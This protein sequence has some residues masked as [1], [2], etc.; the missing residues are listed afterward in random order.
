[1][2]DVLAAAA[3]SDRVLAF[4]PPATAH[5]TPALEQAGRAATARCVRPA[6]GS[7]PRTVITWRRNE[8]E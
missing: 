5:E 1:M 4:P 2:D 6:R 7:R 3:D 8:H